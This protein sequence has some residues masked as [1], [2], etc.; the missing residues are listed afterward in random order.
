MSTLSF[1]S[2]LTYNLDP[3][4]HIPLRSPHTGEIEDWGLVDS[5]ED[6][7]AFGGLPIGMMRQM[8]QQLRYMESGT[9]EKQFVECLIKLKRAKLKEIGEGDRLKRDYI[10]KITMKDLKTR[11]GTEDLIWRRVRVS[12]ETKLSTFQDKVLQPLMGW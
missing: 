2:S 1:G 9:P 6:E 7:E 12:G 4:E 3:N 5:Q 8:T 11:D 10:L